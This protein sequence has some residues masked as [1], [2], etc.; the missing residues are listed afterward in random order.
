MFCLLVRDEDVFL[1]ILLLSH[2]SVRGNNFRRI[3][4]IYGDLEQISALRPAQD[5]QGCI[6]C[7]RYESARGL[8]TVRIC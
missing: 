2:D 6:P 1:E 4:I 8:H 3:G 7:L 5:R